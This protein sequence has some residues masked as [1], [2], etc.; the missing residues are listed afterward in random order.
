[1]D[2]LLTS[3]STRTAACTVGATMAEMTQPLQPELVKSATEDDDNSSTASGHDKALEYLLRYETM[4]RQQ[5]AED[6]ATLAHLRPL[7]R[8]IETLGGKETKEMP[9]DMEDIMARE[10]SFA[11]LQKALVVLDNDSSQV[12]TTDRQL[13]LVLRT[14]AKKTPETD[15]E[16]ISWAEFY[17]CYKTVVAGMQTLQYVPSQ[18]LVRSRTKDRTLSILSLFEPPSTKLFNEDVPRTIHTGEEE[19]L[20]GDR[21]YMM[22]EV[23]KQRRNT[24]LI[25]FLA[26]AAALLLGVP[27][28]EIDNVVSYVKSAIAPWMPVHNKPPV[29]VRPNDT[30]TFHHFH[31]SPLEDAVPSEVVA[32]EHPTTA[33][34]NDGAAVA[35]LAGVTGVA[36]APLVLKAATLLQTGGLPGMGFV[37]VVTLVVAPVIKSL[38]DLFGKL[39]HKRS[40]GKKK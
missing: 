2:D 33:H 29:Q 37:A 16:C 39:L 14:L 4:V 20:E 17:Q 26:V 21:Y 7:L 19:A 1:M 8:R 34:E 13:M 15:G 10:V 12:M 22:P 24:M 27:I 23:R 40:I 31:M 30:N 3:T 18:S 25:V 6:V 11:Q 9:E 35:V 32:V 38:E 5:D 36:V 28:I